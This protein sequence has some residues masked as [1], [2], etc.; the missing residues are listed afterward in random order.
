MRI[1]SGIFILVIMFSFVSCVSYFNLK[2]EIADAEGS[3][4]AVISGINNEPNL[5]FAMMLT[6]SL[7]KHSRLK[8]MS[9][10]KI[11]EAI[12]YYPFRIEG[13]WKFAYVDIEPAY[14][15]MN[16]EKIREIQK[17]LG[18]KYL[19]V[20]WTPVET[21]YTI[22][23]A[24]NVYELHTISQLFEFPEGEPIGGS[25]FVI[26]KHPGMFSSMG[27]SKRD[28]MMYYADNVAKE[29]SEKMK[30]IKGDNS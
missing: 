29:I 24:G 8:V 20:I 11:A 27:K 12:E 30:V 7:Q 1:K 15:K 9:Q 10:K 4:I 14:G 16:I 6:A 25:K 23:N 17:R 18:V 21:S 13:P 26:A 22:Q 3:E 2:K 5:S 19:Y 28:V